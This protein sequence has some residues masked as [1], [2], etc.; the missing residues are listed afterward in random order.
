M[1]TVFSYDWIACVL[2]VVSPWRLYTNLNYSMELVFE[3][4]LQCLIGFDKLLK[5]PDLS[6]SGVC[7]A[8]DL[9]DLN[10]EVLRANLNGD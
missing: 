7:L 9:E 8:G 5:L 1:L 6:R 4:F 3:S 2:I 10:G